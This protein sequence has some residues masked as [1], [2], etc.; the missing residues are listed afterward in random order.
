VQRSAIVKD[1]QSGGWFTGVAELREASGRAWVSFE[2]RLK[3]LNPPLTE[4]K[5]AVSGSASS[6][7][8]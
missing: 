5:P 3:G 8:P 7:K 2:M 4:P 6:P 1:L